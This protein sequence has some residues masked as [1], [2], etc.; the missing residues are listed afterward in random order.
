LRF[1]VWSPALLY[2][3]DANLQLGTAH[4]AAATKQY[5]DV[6]RILA[7]YN[8]GDSRVDRWSRKTGANDPELFTEQ[9]PFVETRDYVRVVQRN[10]DMYRLL[11][12]LK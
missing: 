8:A 7:A 9:I 11:Y 1:P 2:D 10:R 4:L 5:G 12:G 6:T 3:A